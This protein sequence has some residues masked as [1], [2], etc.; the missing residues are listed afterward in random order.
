MGYTETRCRN[1]FDLYRRGKANHKQITSVYKDKDG[2][3]F[4]L[5]FHTPSSI[6]AKEAKTPIYEEARKVN[7]S[8]TRKDQLAK[9]MNTLA[10]Q[11]KNPKGVYGIESHG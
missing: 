1:Y 6:K 10:E 9:Q 3:T 11:V 7:T 5:Q 4:E 2:H 8:A